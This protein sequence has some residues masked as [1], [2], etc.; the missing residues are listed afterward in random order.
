MTLIKHSPDLRHQP[1]QARSRRRLE[2]ILDHAGALLE[3]EGAEALN[4]NRLSQEA[5]VPIASLYHYFPNKQAILFTLAERWLASV[6]AVTDAVEARVRP[7]DGIE[8]YMDAVISALSICYQE[9]LGLVE[10]QRGLDLIP[11]LA[12]LEE[13]HDRRALQYLAGA[14]QRGGVRG[15]EAEILLLAETIF[16]S[17]HFLLLWWRGKPAAEKPA[18]LTQIKQMCLRYIAGRQNDEEIE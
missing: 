2:L 11:E 3:T 14:L 13:Q 6:L 9:T 15:T 8:D 10:L 7:E 16:I 4:T 1:L 17:V 18:A 12:S 5:G